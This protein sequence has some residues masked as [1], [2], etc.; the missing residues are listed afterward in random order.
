M[1]TTVVVAKSFEEK[2]SEKIK[3]NIGDLIEPADLK[4]LVEKGIDK[5]LFE[6][7]NVSSNYGS[8]TVNLSLMEK[9]VSEHL[10]KEVRE[11]ANTWIKENP[12]RMEK[13]IKDILQRDVEKV[14]IQSLSHIFS[15]PAQM[16]MDTALQQF[17]ARLG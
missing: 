14:V 11:A 2:I 1:N 12:E 3:E 17:K 16:M 9:L 8:P 15:Y 10:Q 7:V 4:R 5:F 13:C 6:R